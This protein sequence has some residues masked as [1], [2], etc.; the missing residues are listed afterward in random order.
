MTDIMYT[1]P[2]DPTVKK[3]IINAQCVKDG[4]GPIIEHTNQAYLAD[5]AVVSKPSLS[6]RAVK[7]RTAP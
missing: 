1:A 4:T 6:V 3:I 5:A 2:S 7:D